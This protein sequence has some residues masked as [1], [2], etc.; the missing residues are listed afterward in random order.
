MSS[1][2]VKQTSFDFFS[3][4]TFY[5]TFHHWSRHSYSTSWRDRLFLLLRS[6]IELS[7]LFR[8]RTWRSSSSSYFFFFPRIWTID[9]FDKVSKNLG[10]LTTLTVQVLV[11]NL[12]DIMWIGV[13]FVVW[14]QSTLLCVRV[15]QS[16][17]RSLNSSL[18]DVLIIL[19]AVFAVF[20]HPGIAS[21]R[22]RRIS[23]S[24]NRYRKNADLVK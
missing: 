7:S 10:L 14:M 3:S 9:L 22:P 4:M 19:F 8:I 11:L 5:F 23:F 13:S 12:L 18:D 21:T 17:F 24:V 16:I 1:I 20:F 15:G 2:F 6:G